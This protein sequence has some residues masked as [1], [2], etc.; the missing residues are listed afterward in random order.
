MRFPMTPIHM[1]ED[2]QQTVVMLED[3]VSA[4][5][6]CNIFN[7]S[8]LNISIRF[9]NV[10]DVLLVL[11]SADETAKARSDYSKFVQALSRYHTENCIRGPLI[12]STNN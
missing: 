4:Q 6:G 5:I 12:D 7:P 2:K 10:S 1:F 9:K 11:Y 8:D 3:V